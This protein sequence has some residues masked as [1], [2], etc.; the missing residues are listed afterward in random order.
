MHV[1]LSWPVSM[2]VPLFLSVSLVPLSNRVHHS[3][4]QAE[5]PHVSPYFFD[6]GQTFR[7]TPYLA[8]IGPSER[9]NPTSEADRILFFMIDNNLV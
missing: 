5:R 6:V 4:S 9:I 7:L 3:K 2:L 8:G 1:N